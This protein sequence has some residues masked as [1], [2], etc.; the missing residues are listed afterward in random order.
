M[1]N[2]SLDKTLKE[3]EK[4][5]Q[6]LEQERARRQRAQ[7]IVSGQPFVNGFRIMDDVAEVVLKA[8][9]DHC[10]N[11]ESGNVSYTLDIFPQ[12][13]AKSVSLEIEKLV[14]YGV[15]ASYIPWPNGGI[16]TL[17]PSAFTY[18]GKKA[19]ALGKTES[20]TDNVNQV[21]FISHRSTDQAVA[22]MLRDYLVG[23]GI[24]NDCIFCSSLP[25]ND[26][27]HI[28][29]R[30]VKEKIATSVINIAI[31]SKE[32]YESAYCVNE[33]GIIW[34]H[35]QTPAV[36]IGLPEI[37]HTN[38]QGFLNNDYKLR[39]LDNANDISEIYDIVQ[40]TLHSSQ[41]S[42]S[43]MTAAS[44]KLIQRYTEHL[45][46]RVATTPT[47][48]SINVSVDELTTDDER[49]VMYYILTKKIRRIK[50]CDIYAWMT[51]SEIYNIN[52]DNALDL[53]ASLGAGSYESGVLEMDINV[54][55]KYT[56]SADEFVRSLEP[57]VEEYRILGKDRF[58]ELWDTGVFTDADKL[59]VAY[60]IQSRISTLGDGWQTDGQVKQIQQWEERSCLDGTLSGAYSACLNQF[61]GNNFV[62]ESA[63]TDHGNVKEHTICPSLKSFLLDGKFP[64]WE[65]LESVIEEHNNRLPF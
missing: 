63:W 56:A 39:R 10:T 30:E 28:I 23:A 3:A 35:E 36:V 29:S 46:N 52:V 33:A 49:V 50:K 58:V 16:V 25:G 42:F 34:L 24:P 11:Q 59:F 17:L 57:T 43:V 27:R 55:R 37:N 6:K 45:S 15:V 38:M 48:E 44:Q 31:L 9:T 5:S 14:Q 1:A 53:L 13:I 47:A 18:F 22:D 8:L 7:S 61:I 19:E 54:F 21:I 65:D 4:K 40:R 64:Y 32:Y 60:I 20:E 12:S 41:V 2:N 26:V 51:Q 62:Y